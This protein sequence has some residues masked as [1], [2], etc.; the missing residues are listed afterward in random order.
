MMMQQSRIGVKKS[1]GQFLVEGAFLKADDLKKAEEIAA[2]TGKRIAQVLI[3]QKLVGQETL[4]TVLSLQFNMAIVDLRQY[5]IQPQAVELIPEDMARQNNILGLSVE[6]DTLTVAIDDPENLQLFDS[7]SVITKKQ[8]R[9]VIPLHGGIKEAID[10]HYKMTARL[11]KQ[12]TEVVRQAPQARPIAEPT[13]VAAEAIAQAPVV[14]AVEMLIQQA[15]KDRASDIHVEPKEDG[16][17]IRYRIDGVLHSVV[18]LPLGVH[19]AIISR[20]KVLSNMNIAE[21]RRPQD[22]Q[23]SMKVDGKDIDFRVATIETSHG[24]MMVIR[25][26][27]KAST[28]QKLDNLGFQQ[29]GLDHFKRI[30]R[31]AYGMVLVSGPTGSGKTT[32][33]YAALN[34][35]DSKARNIMTIEDPIEYHFEGI[36]QIQV[37]R[38]ADIT[39]ATGLRAIMRLDPD[40]ILVGEIR[41]KETANTAIQAA[42]TGH[43]VLSSIHANDAVGAL[44]RL[45]DLGVEPFLV[46]S[47]VIAA[48]SQ[49]LVR[50]VCPYCST[51]QR[52]TPDE[53]MAYQ[54]EMGEVRTDFTFGRGCNF[55]SRTGYMGRVG[56]FEVLP[57]TEQIRQQVGKDTPAGEVKAQALREGMITMR[58]DGMLK[59]R[60]GITTPGEVVRNVFSIG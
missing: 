48:L 51:V 32:T 27:D 49:R 37:N 5:S 35:L 13:A 59:A 28:I 10:A 22:G 54:Q 30:L 12:V 2:R 58:R 16:V 15:V 42:L 55:C 46:T 52:S 3:E 44:T 21:R 18:S 8:I 34:E 40:V 23:F 33:L 9:P 53:V 43:L 24:E 14:R 26:L 20:V 57:L 39:F 38:Q 4:A 60:D 45:V 1:V 25:V 31:S 6:S 56:V 19:A 47:A 7:L 17:R 41:D 50:K 11:Q 36:Q 29:G